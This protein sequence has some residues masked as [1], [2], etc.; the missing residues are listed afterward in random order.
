MQFCLPA[1]LVIAIALTL[2]AGSLLNSPCS[3]DKAFVHSINPLQSHA[4]SLDGC[5]FALNCHNTIEH[6]DGAAW[7]SRLMRT[8]DVQPR[9]HL[10][11]VLVQAP[12]S[13]R[14][15]LSNLLARHMQ[16]QLVPYLVALFH[17]AQVATCQHDAFGDTGMAVMP[18]NTGSNNGAGSTDSEQPWLARQGPE[19]CKC[20]LQSPHMR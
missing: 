6:P 4:S 14:G 12:T 20:T 8:G 10:H 9:T 7:P 16:S 1:G 11:L 15:W 17:R 19:S 18:R 13:Q 3:H 5:S 2:E